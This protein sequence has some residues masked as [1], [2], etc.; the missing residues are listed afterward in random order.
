MTSDLEVFGNALR[1][2][3]GLEPLYGRE[4]TEQTRANDTKRFYVASRPVRDAQTPRRGEGSYGTHLF[5]I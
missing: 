2:V 5:C 4:L 3:L 1:E